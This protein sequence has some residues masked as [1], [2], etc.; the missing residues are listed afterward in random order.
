MITFIAQ[1][2]LRQSVLL[3]K[4]KWMLRNIPK[5][6]CKLLNSA[7][8]YVFSQISYPTLNG[9][10][11]LAL[12]KKKTK[13]PPYRQP[14]SGRLG[15]PPVFIQSLPIRTTHYRKHQ[16]KRTFCHGAASDPNTSTSFPS[17][18]SSYSAHE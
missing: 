3:L 11:K 16:E 1:D 10:F 14:Y 4:P 7:K 15:R 2:R 12:R 18:S 8:R 5:Q 13:L 17:L 9:R 6:I